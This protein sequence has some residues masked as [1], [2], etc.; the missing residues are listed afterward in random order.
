M[1]FKNHKNWIDF[2]L[3]FVGDYMR[4]VHSYLPATTSS[5]NNSSGSIRNKNI[6]T[7]IFYLIWSF[8]IRYTIYSTQY[9]PS[10]TLLILS[11]A[12]YI[13][14]F[15]INHSPVLPW[16]T[17]STHNSS[18]SIRNKNIYICSILY[19]TDNIQYIIHYVAHNLVWII[20]LCII[21][22]LI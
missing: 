22:S 14:V 19:Y 10:S 16:A 18:G 15:K 6:H 5:T 21:L 3:F 12:P 13:T 1:N 11:Y 4:E 8:S 2:L 9:I 17:S 20:Y 7:N